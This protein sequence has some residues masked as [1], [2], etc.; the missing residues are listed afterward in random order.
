MKKLLIVAEFPAPYR[1]DVFKQ[2]SKSYE[3]KVYFEL[4]Q[5]QKRNAEWLN[6]EGLASQILDNIKSRK[7]F[8]SNI[9]KLKRYDAVILYNNCLKYSIFLEVICK[10]SNMPFFVNCDGCNDIEEKNIIKKCIKNYIMKGAEGYFAGSKSAYN[11]FRYYGAKSE[12]IYLHN[13]TSLH[14]CDIEKKVCTSDEKILLKK[15]LNI[16]EKYSIITVGRHIECKGFDIVLQAARK[17]DD[18]I[19]IYIVGGTPS[20]ENAEYKNRYQLEH[21]HFLDFKNSD[22]LKEYYLASDL[23]VLMTRG[24]TWGLVINEAMANGLPIITTNRCVAGVELIDNGVNGYIIDVDDSKEL[25]EKTLLILHDDELRNSISRNNINKI[26]NNTVENIGN[27]H[28]KVLS[29]FFLNKG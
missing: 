19:G 24:D 20:E 2:L 7:N 11:Y 22:V 28:I 5:D 21:V 18:N 13:F 9:I 27:K 8:L 12:R 15:K 3:I 10:I 16:I 4:Q 29:D 1:V 23:F 26:Q 14:L 17:L 25:L 6:R